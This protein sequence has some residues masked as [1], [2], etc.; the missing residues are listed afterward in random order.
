MLKNSCEKKKKDRVVMKGQIHDSCSSILQPHLEFALA[1]LP[2]V[3][4]FLFCWNL[5][6]QIAGVVLCTRT[7]VEK[8]QQGVL[9]LLEFGSIQLL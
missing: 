2:A 9:E 8:K 3:H 5:C 7:R 4:F 6:E 1:A